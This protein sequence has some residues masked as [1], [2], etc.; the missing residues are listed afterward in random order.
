MYRPLPPCVTIK[1]S[2][3]HGMGIF[4]IETIYPGTD[5][6]IAHIKLDGFPHGYCRTPLGG[7]YNHSDDPNC[8]LISGTDIVHHDYM[9]YWPEPK[10]K[11]ATFFYLVKRLMVTR[12]INQGE[13]ITCSYTLYDLEAD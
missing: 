3:I 9:E 13:E 5:L 1:K 8:R 6:G 7:F 4:A 10:I 12:N 11:E 2:E